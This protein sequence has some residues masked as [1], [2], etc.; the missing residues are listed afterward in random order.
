VISP[1]RRD[2]FGWQY[3]TVSEV[4]VW[5]WSASIVEVKLALRCNAALLRLYYSAES[6]A[7]CS[8]GSSV[9][10]CADAQELAGIRRGGRGRRCLA[11]LTP[12][13]RSTK[14]PSAKHQA[15]STKRDA[16]RTYTFK[17]DDGPNIGSKDPTI[18]PLSRVRSLSEWKLRL[19]SLEPKSR[20]HTAPYRIA[21][22][23]FTPHYSAPNRTKPYQTA[24]LGTVRNKPHQAAPRRSVSC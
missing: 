24:P 6:R 13:N 2:G 21:P 14:T 10:G 19:S 1:R 7:G 11:R 22:S 20:L 23:R 16:S 12:H 3:E 5:N 8:V 17:S 4:A 9:I 15:P 18:E